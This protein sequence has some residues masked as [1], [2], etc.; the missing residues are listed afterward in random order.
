MKEMHID[1]TIERYV[2]G[3]M[4]TGER[5]AFESRMGSSP[6]LAREVR[7]AEEIKMALASF[8]TPACPDA[9]I[10]RL[11]RDIGRQSPLAALTSRWQTVAVA[12]AILFGLIVF[13]NQQMSA[14]A[15]V[16]QAVED[17]RWALQFVSDLGSTS[18]GANRSQIIESAVLDPIQHALDFVFVDENY[19]DKNE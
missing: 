5:E 6:D 17:A 1:E 11:Y 14:G 19:N 9:V 2:D 12:C 7:L 13:T 15:E 8:E 16:D 18:D 4:T 10:D 3:E